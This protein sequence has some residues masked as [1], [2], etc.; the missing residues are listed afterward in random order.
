MATKSGA[1]LHN[2]LKDCLDRRRDAQ[3]LRRL[4]LPDRSHI[5]FSSNDFLSLSHDETLKSEYLAELQGQ[6]EGLGSGGSRLLDGN[7]RYAEELERK[8]ASFHRSEAG[9]L[10]N[11]GYDANTGFFS[12]VPQPGDI[13]VY[14]EL[15]HASVHDGMRMSRASKKL[16]FPHNSVEGL[17]DVISRAC[18]ICSNGDCNVI[19][20]VEAIYSMDGDVAP[21]TEIVAVV[22]E[23]V[24]LN[25]GHVVVDE[26]HAT[27]VLGAYGRGLVCNLG[28]EDRVFA[29]LHTFGKSLAGNGAIILGSSVLRDYLV[30]YAR[31]LIY[32]TFLSYPCLALIHTSYEFM[33]SGK[34]VP[35]QNYLRCLVQ[36]FHRTLSQLQLLDPASRQMLQIPSTC[37]QSPIFS[38][39]LQYPRQ[40]AH[41]LQQRGM[42]VRPIM[43]PT[44]PMGTQRIRICL[45]AGNTVT[46]VMSLAQALFEWCRLHCPAVP[47][48]DPELRFP[49]KS[50]I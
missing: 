41:Y 24:G 31:P 8:I 50:R 33:K 12:C 16:P 25:R 48:I 1:D 23:L 22:E 35:L 45:H 36:T 13:I 10:F 21:L 32:T 6:D 27:G 30:N 47:V 40:L 14:D 38:I 34:T 39:Q 44:V 37:P 28:L 19:V 26:A 18:Q 4:V 3:T 2:K 9:L 49:L 43:P 17:R 46:Q 11:S 7:S 15:V 5:D 20:A 42:M 29:R